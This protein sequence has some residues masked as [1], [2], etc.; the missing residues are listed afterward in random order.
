M[1][2]L[3][4][5]RFR[6][7][8]MAIFSILFLISAFV[9]D[10]DNGLIQDLPMGAGF[11]ASVLVTLRVVIYVTLLHLSRRALLDYIDLEVYFN[12]AKETPQAAALALLAVS[13]MMICVTLLIFMAIK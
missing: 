1:S 9:G 6:Y 5:M 8:Y 10:P 3:R 11:V 12:K 2:L 13:V 4:K 7:V